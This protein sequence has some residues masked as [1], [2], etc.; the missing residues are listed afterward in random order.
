MGIQKLPFA[1]LEIMQIIWDN[2]EVG[3]T[4][5]YISERLVGKKDWAVTT[6]LNFLMRLVNRGFL[7]VHKE[8]KTNIYTSLVSEEEYLEF[9][10]KS[11]LDRLH[12]NSLKSLVASL[13]R[14][15]AIS[16]SDLEELKDYIDERAGEL[17][18]DL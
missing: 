9:E 13:Y 6:I 14:G 17:S 11:F 2:K 8:G 16:Q 1:E 18:D 7:A 5:V 4:A 3:T 12:G 15:K 10:S